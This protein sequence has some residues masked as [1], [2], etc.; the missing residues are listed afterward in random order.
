MKVF[1]DAGRDS[2]HMLKHGVTVSTRDA[3]G[4]QFCNE[5]LQPGRA[6][7]IDLMA[8][9]SLAQRMF[10]KALKRYGNDEY[11]ISRAR[12]GDTSNPFYLTRRWLRK[13]SPEARALFIADMQTF[14]TSLVEQD[15]SDA[16]IRAASL[17]EQ[18]HEG[19]ENVIQLKLQENV[20]AYLAEARNVF[21]AS[22]AHKLL[23]ASMCERR[24]AS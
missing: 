18:E 11:R 10:T 12:A 3:K 13:A 5:K 7:R 8:A 2:A 23:L 1:Q 20:E 17:C 24:L 19:D 15:V 14:V 9:A 16:A 21:A 6:D 22:A 4:E